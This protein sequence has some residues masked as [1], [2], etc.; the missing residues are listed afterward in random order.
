MLEIN[1]QLIFLAWICFDNRSY[2]SDLSIFIKAFIWPFRSRGI[3]C[4]TNI[5]F[6]NIKWKVKIFFF[7]VWMGLLI[8]IFFYR[9]RGTYCC[10]LVVFCNLG[11][12]L[13]FIMGSFISYAMTP[14]ILLTLPIVFLLTFPFFPETPH[15]LIKNGRLEVCYFYSQ[16]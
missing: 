16:Y 13:S 8:F 1:Y 2:W 9:V 10:L 11:I 14:I 6:R 5:C 7:N 3:S 12:L 15:F 4:Y